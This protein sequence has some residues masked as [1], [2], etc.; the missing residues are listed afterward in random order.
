[1]KHCVD[2][3]YPEK[4]AR[5]QVNTKQFLKCSSWQQKIVFQSQWLIWIY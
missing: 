5:N 4:K 1:M 2:T 3:L